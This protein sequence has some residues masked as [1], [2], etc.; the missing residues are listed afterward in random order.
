MERWF[1]ADLPDPAHPIQIEN[2]LVADNEQFLQFSLSDQQP[3]KRILMGP[4]NMPA[5]TPW[6]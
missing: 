4:G 3:V 1:E 5:R 6:S 2:P